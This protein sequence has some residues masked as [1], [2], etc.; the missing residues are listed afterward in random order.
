MGHESD[1]SPLDRVS[2]SDPYPYSTKA[3][4]PQNIGIVHPTDI[5][6]GPTDVSSVCSHKHY[7]Q[8]AP[9]LRALVLGANDGLV[10]IASLMMGVGAVNNGVK[11]MVVSGLA[12]LVAGACSMAIGEFVSVFS[13]R[14]SE[15]ADV[16]KERQVLANALHAIL[17]YLRMKSVPLKF[18]TTEFF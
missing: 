1:I 14:D 9:W 13:Q 17:F 3:T 15:K 16:E 11:T 2:L 12:G 18:C 5:E 6:G 10:S 4:T 7:S 8:R